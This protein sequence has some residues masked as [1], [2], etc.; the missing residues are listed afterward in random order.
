MTKW[1]LVLAAVLLPLLQAQ[2][3]TLTPDGT[4]PLPGVS[5]R[6]DHLAAD[7]ARKR[8]FVAELGNGT[9]DI[10]DLATRKVIHRIQGL[11]EPQGIVYA[12]RADLIAVA[13]GG[14]GTVRLYGGEDFKPRG[15]IRL[16][17]DADNVRLDPR[18]GNLVVG[19]GSGALAVIDPVKAQ[20]IRDIALPG[21][22]RN[23]IF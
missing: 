15:M 19:Y 10:V 9:V 1:R 4:I 8:L 5:G 22:H 17:D 3:A 13:S 7:V 18:T 12:P 16:G 20:K 23:C 14:D 11:K 21:H 2:A 6:I